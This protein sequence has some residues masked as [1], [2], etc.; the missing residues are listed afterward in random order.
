MYGDTIIQYTHNRVTHT[1]VECMVILLVILLPIVGNGIAGL[2]AE[3]W[4]F[5]TNV[6]GDD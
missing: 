5:E 4:N 6:N 2:A 1:Q 3:Y